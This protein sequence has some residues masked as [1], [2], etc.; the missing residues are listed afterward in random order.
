MHTTWHIV[1]AI[2]EYVSLLVQIL[3]LKWHDGFTQYNITADFTTWLVIICSLRLLLYFSMQEAHKSNKFTPHKA[4]NHITNFIISCGYESCTSQMTISARFLFCADT[5]LHGSCNMLL[6]WWLWT[7]SWPSQ[8]LTVDELS[9]QLCPLL[10][11]A[12]FPQK[13]LPV[14]QC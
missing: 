10:L 11:M 9:R 8:C 13:I 5:R 4:E 2:T 3:Q 12:S 6:H 14:I 7:F 1:L